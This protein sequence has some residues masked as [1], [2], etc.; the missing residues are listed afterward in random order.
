MQL[1]REK[2]HVPGGFHEQVPGST[3][4]LWLIEMSHSMPSLLSFEFPGDV[5]VEG[6]KAVVDG[7]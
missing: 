2:Q 5:D 1:A 4:S 3:P 6:L 7:V